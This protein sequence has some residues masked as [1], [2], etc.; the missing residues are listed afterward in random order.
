[1]LKGLYVCCRH[2]R[3]IGCNE[4]PGDSA[5]EVIVRSRGGIG[6][7]ERGA[8]RGA[9]AQSNN[10][11]VADGGGQYLTLEASE[12]SKDSTVSASQNGLTNGR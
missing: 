4:I 1:M 6:D 2:V 11:R 9:F 10:R 8:T 5:A 7:L 12:E 3:R